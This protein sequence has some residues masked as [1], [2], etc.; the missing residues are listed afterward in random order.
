MFKRYVAPLL[1]RFAPKKIRDSVFFGGAFSSKID[2][3]TLKCKRFFFFFLKINLIKACKSVFHYL[4]WGTPRCRSQNWNTAGASFFVSS[5]WI[6][7]VSCTV[8]RAKI[9][10]WTPHCIWTLAFILT[11]T[12]YGGQY[13]VSGLNLGACH[14]PPPPQNR[15]RERKVYHNFVLILYNFVHR[16]PNFV[17]H[18]PLR[19]RQFK[20]G[21]LVTCSPPP[22]NA[23]ST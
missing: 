7:S 15:F 8:P 2:I 20:F 14:R 5:A 13:L 3:T 10:G 6:G 22:R 12:S 16:V 23:V 11:S 9:P 1:S 17:P 18:S 21:G 4:F 19:H